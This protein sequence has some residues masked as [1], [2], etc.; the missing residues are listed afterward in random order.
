MVPDDPRMVQ[1]GSLDLIHKSILCRNPGRKVPKP[2]G[3]HE[4][5]IKVIII[6]IIMILT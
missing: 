3:K 2:I 5:K 6:L 1:P 4:T